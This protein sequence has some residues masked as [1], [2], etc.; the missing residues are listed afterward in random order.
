MC[1]IH[2]L[3]RRGKVLML[4]STASK[5]LEDV[6]MKIKRAATWI[7]AA[8]I[9]ALPCATA[10]AEPYNIYVITALTGQSAFLGSEEAKGLAVLEA[11]V[12]K[13]GGVRGRQIH[14]VIQDDQSIAQN[15]VE[16]LNESIAKKIPVLL[17]TSLVSGCGAMLPVISNGPVVYCFSPGIH[18]PAGSYM[19]SASISTADYIVAT[20]RYL[21][22][23][24]LHKIALMTSTD[25]TGQDADRSI[26]AAVNAPENGG[27]L[28]I[29]DREHF[30]VTDLS[31]AAQISKIKASG[32]QV[33]ILWTVG[34]PFGTL[35]REAVQGGLDIPL[36]T[37]AGNLN[38]AQLEGY[39]S[40]MPDNL[41]IM[42]APWAGPN[43][44][45]NPAFRKNIAAY[46]DA[47]KPSGI[48]PD[49]GYSLS[50]DPAL[51]ILDAFR[52]LGFD[53]TAAQIR[54][55][56]A[57]TKGFVGING[58]YDFATVPQRGIDIN[59][60]VMVRWDKKTKSLIGVSKPGGVAL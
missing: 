32:A 3:D 34:T 29:V 59:W 37:S 7:L 49:E 17:G 43:A 58:V 51:L 22:S 1:P 50:W 13:A 53:A 54:D 52:H 55:Y 44:F 46:V 21:K 23:K 42:A 11:Q 15:S 35:L 48:R 24:G 41:L 28:S 30:N 60:L 4:P 31:V 12:N 39:D 9:G 19:F 2:A 16:L 40:F 57:G 14:F 45:T 36:I 56:I 5:P 20:M 33:A 25:A 38:Y 26:D 8:L 18:P 47:F 27:T 10:A 6:W